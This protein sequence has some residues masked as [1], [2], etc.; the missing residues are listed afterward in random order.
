MKNVTSE[1][2]TQNLVNKKNKNVVQPY[3]S[4]VQFVFSSEDDDDKER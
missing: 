3:N 2:A 4:V 1:T